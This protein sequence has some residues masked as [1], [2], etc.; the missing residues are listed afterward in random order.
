MGKFDASPPIRFDAGQKLDQMASPTKPKKMATI[1]RHWT[2]LGRVARV[3]FSRTLSDNLAKTPPPLAN[4]KPP[5]VDFEAD[6]AAAEQA[7]KTVKDLEQQLTEAR[8]IAKQKADKC[9]AN[10]EILA[11]RAADATDGDPAQLVAIGFVVSTGT[12]QAVGPMPKPTELTLTTSDNEGAIDW[13]IDANP[14]ASTNQTR[15]TATPTDPNSWKEQ[16]PVTQSSGT[17]SGLPSGVR[18]YVEA[19]YIGPLGPGPWSDLASKMVP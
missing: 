1:L 2:R 5:L 18:Q 4:P 10:I 3:G 16:T 15:T 8:L 7:E 13:Q 9:V 19:R 17:I 12:P 6:T 14:G 11:V